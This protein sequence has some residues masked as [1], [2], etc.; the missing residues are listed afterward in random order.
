MLH[1]LQQPMKS[2]SELL[3]T[4]I[5]RT[6]VSDA[7]LA[8]RLGVSRQTIFR[9]REGQ[10]QR[11]RYRKDVLDL[12]RK[13]RLSEEEA[14]QLL[15]AAGF[16]P[17]DGSSLP[18]IAAAD[19]GQGRTRLPKRWRIGLVIGAV[20]LVLA[21]WLLVSPDAKPEPADKGEQLIL[22]S[23]FTQAGGQLGFNVAG[24]LEEAIRA[25]IEELALEAVRVETYHDPIAAELSAQSLLEEL[26]ATLI[27]WGEYDSGRVVAQ[28]LSRDLTGKPLARERSWLLESAQNLPA[29]I[30]LELPQE[31]SWL[32]LFA[33]GRS[34]QAQG[35]FDQAQE[36]YE[37][38][39]QHIGENRAG[40][41]QLYF[42][43]GFAEG[44]K[45]DGDLSRVIAY[46][47]EVLSRQP[48]YAAALN[49]RAAAYLQRDAGGDL[50]RA[51][52][53]LLD[54]LEIA[55]ENANLHLNLGLVRIWL[56]HDL[57]GAI[58]SFRQ[59][60]DLDPDSAGIQNALCW[61]LSLAGRPAQALA[62]CDR[63]IALEPA[64]SH[65]DSLGLALALLGRTTEA[66]E[67]F[68][69]GLELFE[70]T[71]PENFAVISPSR[72]AWIA[73]LEAG[74]DPFDEA[75]LQSLL[76]E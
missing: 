64:A 39:L 30:N 71:E 45:E 76:Q 18:V 60:A 15:L 22:I 33:I 2:F 24:R 44:V 35:E 67:A 37:A 56:E 23:E 54:G 9:W 19:V 50:E 34:L 66:V 32:A 8:R 25:A 27:V 7:E 48:H 17:E 14:N 4:F 53:D 41:A 52:E 3:S 42:Y 75:T 36:L 38:A 58:A 73:A 69:T 57:E 49:N 20:L 1:S 6:G 65:Y 28:I 51:R 16:P 12:V 40:A 13:L 29:T 62:Y 72:L 26:D 46:Y 68:R 61:N 63:A 74:E 59:A 43:L 10:I 55:P 47:S 21:V 70:Q 11:P 5:Q 31:V